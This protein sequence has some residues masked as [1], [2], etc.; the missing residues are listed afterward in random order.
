MRHDDDNFDPP[1][2]SSTSVKFP[3]ARLGDETSDGCK[4]VGKAPKSM[5]VGGATGA[6]TGLFVCVGDIVGENVASSVKNE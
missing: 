1:L 5:G 6:G 4:G 2:P 3:R